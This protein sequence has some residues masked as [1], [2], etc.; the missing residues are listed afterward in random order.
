MHM[1]D[2]SSS[3]AQSAR[4]EAEFLEALDHPNITKYG[5]M[6]L[7]VQVGDICVHAGTSTILKRGASFG[8]HAVS[9][10]FRFRKKLI[11]S[12]AAL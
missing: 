9:P 4:K 10:E 12:L 3:E 2:M 1:K 6:L 7:Y 8:E 11:R 5:L